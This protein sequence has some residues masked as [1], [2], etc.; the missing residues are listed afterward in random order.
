MTSIATKI[1]QW[2]QQNARDLPWRGDSSHLDKAYAVWLSETMLQ[3][4][5]VATVIPYF[6]KFTQKWATVT[7]MAN[8]PLDHVLAQ[9]AGLGYYARARNLHKCAVIIAT[10]YNG[11][12][13]KNE[14]E[15]LKLPGIGPYTAAA[16]S[17]FAFNNRTV[18][19]DTNIERVISRLFAVNTPLPKA[20][21]E[22]YKHMDT[23]T[24]QNAKEFAQGIMDF[25]NAVCK[26]KNP[27]CKN[28]PVQNNCS[29]PR[30][31]KAE[32]PKKMPKKKKP[33]RY[34]YM[35]V[36]YV[37]NSD[38]I[39]TETRPKK[40]LLGGMQGVPTTDWNDSYPENHNKAPILAN[41]CESGGYKHTFTHFHLHTKVF[42]AH[43]TRIP[44]GYNISNGNNLP[45]VFKKSL[46]CKKPISN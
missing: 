14:S 42:T 33:N 1:L 20:K 36:V 44:D 8:A 22:I 28:C 11:E 30:G 41:W 19:V 10:K 16:I 46:Q 18:V 45:T 21:P 35:Y 27:N 29:A 6:T 43:T 9:W 13:P 17:A 34:G 37:N 2:Y 38:T 15:L 39:L 40:G 4:T 3:Q 32:Y 12:F 31:A 26:P 5:T 25:A 7:D 24:P 23:I